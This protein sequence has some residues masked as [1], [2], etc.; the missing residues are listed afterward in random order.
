VKGSF[1]KELER[2]F[3][4]FPKYHMKILLWIRQCQSTRL[5]RKVSFPGAVYR[6]KT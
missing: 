5:I 1:H 2:V 4:K 3:D 6:N